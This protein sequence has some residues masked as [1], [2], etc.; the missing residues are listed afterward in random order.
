MN[1]FQRLL[2]FDAWNR[3]I[4][5]AFLVLWAIS[6]IN[7]PYPKYFW[8]QHVPTV[9]VVLAL[10]VAD[11]WLRVSRLS[12]TLILAF[13]SLHLLGAR[14]L[15]SFVPYDDWTDRLVGH[16]VTDLFGFTRN[17]YDRLVHF[18]FGLLL[19]LPVQRCVGRSRVTT[20]FWQT[21]VTVALLMAAGA[22]YEIFEWI[23]A[24]LMAPDWADSFNGQQ[25]DPWDAQADMLLALCGATTAAVLLICCEG[26]HG[27]AS[28]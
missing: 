10:I 18:G 25:G 14:S 23:I 26:R 15:Y 2:P 13:M 12:F 7:V 11:R 27:T 3:G 1:S 8:L 28:Q 17:H 5:A 19:F 4:L 20:R 21:A 24:I 22:A 16:R 9:F 6:C